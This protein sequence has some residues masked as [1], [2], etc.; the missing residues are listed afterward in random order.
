MLLF[1]CGFP[2]GGT[3]LMKT[4]LNAHPDVAING[5]LPR[6]VELDRMG[7]GAATVFTDVAEIERFKAALG[8]LDTWGNVENL[9]VDFRALLAAEGPL[10]MVDALRRCFSSR[11]VCVW[12][13]K[14]PQF[15][16]QM[17]RLHRLFP[18]ARFLVVLR[19]VRDV[20]LSWDRKWGKD[21]VLCAH[22]WATRMAA[23]Q[24]AAQALP[25][26]AALAVR[27][28]DLLDD[29]RSVCERICAFLDLPFAASMLE[30]HKHVGE[31]I[32][33]KLNYG[34]AIRKDNRRKWVGRVPEPVLRR[35]EEIA[36]PIMTQLGYTPDVATR[37]RPISAR[38][39][40]AGRTRDA[41]AAVLVGNRAS[42]NNTLLE[43]LRTVTRQVQRGLGA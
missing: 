18:Q 12:G 43:R 15:T 35:I 25:P 1:V 2:S 7:F 29:P 19:D 14:T 9:G 40:L 31:R 6:L 10:P 17:P 39:R 38:E 36:L 37:H 23:G 20:C 27:Y 34:E 16:E 33:G 13:S 26:E 22:K 5:E 3:D 32:D 28:E 41:V 42:Q 11:D 30:H 4:V 8:R 24:R 21:M